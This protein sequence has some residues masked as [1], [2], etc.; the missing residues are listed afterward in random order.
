[1]GTCCHSTY[2]V[3][4]QPG[5]DIL[6]QLDVHDRGQAILHVCLTCLRYCCYSVECCDNVLMNIAVEGRRNCDPDLT[7]KLPGL[8]DVLRM[9]AGAEP[10]DKGRHYVIHGILPVL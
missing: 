8:C 2:L 7:G 5:F 10:E 9:H 1:M 6:V 4:C 3:I